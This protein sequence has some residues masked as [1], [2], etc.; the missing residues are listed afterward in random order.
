MSLGHFADQPVRAQQPQ[1]SAHRCHLLTLSPFVVGRHMKA[2]SHIT[3]TK[4]VDCKLSTINCGQQF[5]VD[6]SERIKR[7]IPLSLAS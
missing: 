1:L 5:R 3:I 6:L 7:S 4:T 2:R